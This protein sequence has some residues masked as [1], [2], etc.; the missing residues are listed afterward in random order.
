MD[1][2]PVPAHWIRRNEVTRVP[3]RHVFL[4]T[5][6][7]TVA[8]ARGEVQTFR[9]A[10]G[11][12]EWQSGKA[13]PLRSSGPV[14]LE[15]PRA[16]WTWVD[17]CTVA[18]KRTVVWC[19]NLEFD[20]RISNALVELPALGWALEG[21]RLDRGGAFATWRRDGR[22]LT[23]CD[24]TAF[25]PGSLA[26]VGVMVG[27][28]KPALP[29]ESDDID[30]W[31][32]RCEADVEIL[33]RAV[34]QV[35]DW[36]EGA[37]LGNW[38]P[39]GAGQ[40]WTAY[41]H[42]RLTHPVL[43]HGRPEVATV[44][45]ESAWSGR[46]EAWRHGQLSL[47]PWHEVDFST[48]YCQVALDSD[49]PTRLMGRLSPSAARRYLDPFVGRSALLRCEVVTDTPTVPTRGPDG[50]LWPTGRF[51]SWLWDVEARAARDDGAGVKVLGGWLYASAPA[52]QGWAAWVLELLDR[53]DV[54]LSPLLKVVVKGWTRSVI[55]RFGSR[56]NDWQ[57]FGEAF[58]P[59]L[60]LSTLHDGDAGT[61]RRLLTLDRECYVEGASH[62]S[63]DGAV[64]VMSWIMS[65]ARVR[66]WRMMQ[67]AG[68]DEVAYVDTDGAL[69]TS[70]GLAALQAASIPGLR[71][72]GSYSRVAVYGPKVIVKDGRLKASGIPSKAVKVAERTWEGEVFASLPAALVAGEGD[73]VRV[74]DRS[75]TLAGTDRRRR[76]LDAGRTAPIRL[77]L[78][79]DGMHV[80]A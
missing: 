65:E 42:K 3:R 68:L 50:V 72:K 38:R 61:A 45:R 20:L 23:L 71:L 12:F 16:V 55:G 17:G 46:C 77:D 31:W 79:A 39:T 70:Q 47:G 34:R 7:R 58:L 11:V 5:E 44:E 30:A 69:V 75:W 51:R 37:D 32:R 62:D 41:R 18:S 54:D 78:T 43:H 53:P 25:F 10:V 49:V 33:R 40:G 36:V 27:V 22:T 76:H 73:L 19:H 6:T 35:L 15:S 57:Q 56:V 66:L 4:D 8:S 60:T 9:L 63:P 2:R 67:T 80:L 14:R 26:D 74:T 29:C 59:S 52:L 48:A 21:I 13:N 24:S 64:H 1:D 28:A